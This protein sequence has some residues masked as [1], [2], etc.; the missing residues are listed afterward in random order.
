[1]GGFVLFLVMATEQDRALM[2]EAIKLMRD[3]GVIKKTG[4]PFGAVI[5][6]DGQLIAAS[7]NSVLQDHDPSAHAE[8]NAIRKAC[9]ALGT[10]D[11]SGC[12]MYTSC[13]CCPMC[14]STAYW[15]RLDRVYY[16][17]AWEDYDDLFSDRA[18]SEDLKK[19]LAERHLPQ[20]QLLHAEAVEVWKEFRSLP[21]GARY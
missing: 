11:L 3:A 7:G 14:Y 5:A 8:V 19:P 21:D 18:I 20:E 10:W 15:A 17:A 12:V 1:L 6:K 4:G 13:Q 16:A 2:R 9:K